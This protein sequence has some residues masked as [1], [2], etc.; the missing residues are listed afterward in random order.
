M[1]NRDANLG[2]N[3]GQGTSAPSLVTA[4]A[5]AS[6]SVIVFTLFTFD[7]NSLDA[8]VSLAGGGLTWTRIQNQS[9]A[10]FCF[11][12]FIAYAPSGLASGTTLT[13]THSAPHSPD[14]MMSCV[15]YLGVDTVTITGG[16]NWNTGSTQAWSSGNV[17]AASTSML[18]GAGFTDGY[19]GT[20]TPTGGATEVSDFNAAAQSETMATEEKFN[21]GLS[22]IAGS[23]DDG[24]GHTS[25][26]ISGAIELLAAPVSNPPVSA[27][28]SKF[29]K[30]RLRPENAYS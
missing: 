10:Q 23:W 19:V 5:A 1:P 20:S 22:D 14:N 21:T 17:S 4:A 27:N 2:T 15:S 24:A 18:A 26:W 12:Q 3:S 29:P 30:P 16:G 13:I 28:Y 8:S 7:P 6:G 9:N 25:T 11:T